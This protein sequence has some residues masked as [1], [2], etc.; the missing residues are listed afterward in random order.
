MPFLDK[1][2]EQLKEDLRQAIALDVE[3]ISAYSLIVEEHTQ[4]YLA[5]M[6]DQIKINR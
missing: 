2:I 1:H 3:H 4:L 5:Y 6:K